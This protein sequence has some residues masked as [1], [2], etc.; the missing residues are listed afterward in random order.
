M[1]LERAGLYTHAACR[2]ARASHAP[3]RSGLCHTPGAGRSWGTRWL[4]SVGTAAEATTPFS[5][6]LEVTGRCPERPRTGWATRLRLVRVFRRGCVMFLVAVLCHEPLLQGRLVPDPWLGVSPWAAAVCEP[7]LPLPEVVC[8][9]SGEAPRQRG[10]ICCIITSLS[11]TFPLQDRPGGC[12]FSLGLAPR[13]ACVQTQDPRQSIG[14][15][16]EDAGG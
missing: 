8:G 10:K 5:T 4:R 1:G 16:R 11:K 2:R 6:R 9:D 14:G 7:A 12:A 3:T 13:V 15:R